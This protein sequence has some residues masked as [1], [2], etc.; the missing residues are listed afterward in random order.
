MI[1]PFFDELKDEKTNLGNGKELPPLFDFSD[2][3]IKK[4]T[5]EL[6]TRPD[7]IPKLVP[8]H[9]AQALLENGIDIKNFKPIEIEKL[10][11]LTAMN[12]K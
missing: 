8:K 2:I 11:N 1:H 3:G 4:L 12:N 6:S 9:A 5:I 7:L 10:R